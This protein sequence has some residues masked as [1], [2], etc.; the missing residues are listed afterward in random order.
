[1]NKYIVPVTFK[2]EIKIVIEAE[3]PTDAVEIASDLG[4]HNFPII[5]F[6]HHCIDENITDEATIKLVE[7]TNDKT[8]RHLEL[9]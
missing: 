6:F 5:D 2:V 9:L 8:L 3:N 7:K 4:I 1:M